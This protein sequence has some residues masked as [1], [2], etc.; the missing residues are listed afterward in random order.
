[1]KFIAIACAIVLLT[2]C[3]KITKEWVTT[4]DPVTGVK[5][6][7]YIADAGQGVAMHCEKL[8]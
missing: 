1:M 4:T 3:G 8:P 2:G 5:L 6:S 7:C